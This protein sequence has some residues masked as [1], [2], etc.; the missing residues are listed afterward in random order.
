M[1]EAAPQGELLPYDR[2]LQAHAKLKG[3]SLAV[4]TVPATTAASS[5]PAASATTA[6]A[7]AAA[8]AT[9]ASAFALWARLI[10]NE[11]SSEKI[12]AVQGCDRFFRLRIVTYFGETESPRLPGEAVAKQRE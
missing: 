4:S 6:T 12:L 8:S 1:R 10:Y 3:N 7:M 5:A 2:L 9:G 11:R